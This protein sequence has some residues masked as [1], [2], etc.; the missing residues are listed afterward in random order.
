[1]LI[2]RR[3]ILN[4]IFDAED[5][6]ASQLVHNLESA[7][8]HLASND[9]LTSM[10]GA[11]VAEWDFAIKKGSPDGMPYRPELARADRLLTADELA[12]KY[13][14]ERDAGEHPRYLRQDWISAVALRDTLRGYWQW[15]EAQ[16]EEE[17]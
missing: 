12:E 4:Y 11:T 3:L 9:L 2:K 14:T 5:T 10:T 17:D 13:T 8:Y 1:M 16:L 7:A 15:V 6:E